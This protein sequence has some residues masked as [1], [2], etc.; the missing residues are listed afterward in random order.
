[1]VSDP[2]LP[3]LLAI[4]IGSTGPG[5]TLHGRKLA[6]AVAPAAVALLLM[7]LPFLLNRFLT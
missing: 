5:C 1:M 3:Q 6:H 4:S 7:V 2:C